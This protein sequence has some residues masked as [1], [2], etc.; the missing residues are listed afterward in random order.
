M[1]L[2]VQPEYIDLMEKCYKI[3]F[4]IYN[5]IVFLLGMLVVY[6]VYKLFNSFF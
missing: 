4:D 6:L 1:L 3:G 2:D 5:V